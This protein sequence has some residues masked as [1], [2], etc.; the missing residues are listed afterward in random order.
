MVPKI[1]RSIRDRSK[2]QRHGHVFI[3]G[4]RDSGGIERNVL[5]ISSVLSMILDWES[6]PQVPS[7]RNLMVFQSVADG[8]DL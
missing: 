5:R 6:L 8:H 2:E 3:H 4:E 1:D 7:L